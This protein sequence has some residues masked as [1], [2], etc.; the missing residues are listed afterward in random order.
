[1]IRLI[2]EAIL[3]TI[4]LILWKLLNLLLFPMYLLFGAGILILILTFLNYLIK[5]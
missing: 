5:Q 4:R 1:M 2:I 3:I